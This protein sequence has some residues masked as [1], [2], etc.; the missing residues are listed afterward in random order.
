MAAA[1]WGAVTGAAVVGAG[2]GEVGAVAGAGE[3]AGAKGAR[4]AR[5]VR[6]RTWLRGRAR[7]GGEEG[8]GSWTPLKVVAGR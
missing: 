5:G 2:W 1:A 7:E 4:G 3:G 8:R 6:R